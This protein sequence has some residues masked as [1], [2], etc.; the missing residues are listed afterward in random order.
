LRFLPGAFFEPNGD[1]GIRG[2]FAQAARAAWT[3]RRVLAAG[4]VPTLLT[5]AFEGLTGG[6][7]SN[8]TRAAAGFVLGAAVAAILLQA[9]GSP[10]R[11]K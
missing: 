8:V 3:P 9:L 10:Q 4:A 5:L 6:A 11:I 1:R 7:P 2:R